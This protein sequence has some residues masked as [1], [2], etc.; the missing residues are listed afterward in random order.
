MKR[1]LSQQEIE[2]ILDDLHSNNGYKDV[3]DRV[4]EN[5]KALCR[6]KLTGIEIYPDM[7]PK[8]KEN[9]TLQYD[10]TQIHAGVCV[11]VL[12]A[13][14]LG[15]R[16]TQLVLNS[17][18]WLSE[19]LIRLDGKCQVFPIGK[20]IDNYLKNNLE[21]IEHIPENR[22]E[23]LKMDTP[24]FIPSTDENGMVGWHR[25]EAITRHLPV[26]KLIKITTQS[27]RTVSATRQKSFLRWNGTIF[28]AV[29][30]TDLQIGDIMPT[31]RKLPHVELHQTLD[32]NDLFPK[33]EYLYSSEVIK[34]VEYKKTDSRWWFNNSGKNFIVPQDSM[35]ENI[36]AGMI[37]IP[38]FMSLDSEFGFFIGIYLAEGLT[39]K[40][41]ISIS[42]KDE[43]ILER[44]VNWCNRFNI[45]T[46]RVATNVRN[47]TS[48]DLK[49]HSVL[50]TRLIFK[51]CDTGSSNKFVPKII[52]GAPLECIKGVL[53][54][55]F[56]GDGTINIKSLYISCSSA[57]KSLIEGMQFLLTYFGI[58][59]K[60]SGVQP[61][62]N[63]MLI[64]N[65][66][67][68]LFYEQLE[69][70][71]FVKQE[72]LNGVKDKKYVHE[73]GRF[74]KSYPHDRH[75]Y[76]DA[77]VK[78]EEVDSS[79]Q[80]VYD[81]TVEHTRNFQLFNGVNCLDTFHSSGITVAAVVTGVPRFKELLNTTKNPKGIATRIFF[82]QKFTSLQE[83]RS[84]VQTH[85][86]Y[87]QAKDIIQSHRI[88]KIQIR[89]W[90]PAFLKMEG[91]KSISQKNTGIILQFN[92]RLL[93]IH[94]LGLKYIANRIETEFPKTVCIYSPDCMH[95]VDVWFNNKDYTSAELWR[96]I[97]VISLGGITGLTNIF[98][99][100][101]DDE[102]LVD[103]S[104]FNMWEL[105][106]KSWIEATRTY[107]NHMWEIYEILG[108]EA[109]RE[110]LIAE[111]ITVI[112]TDSYINVRHI[113]LLVD[114][115][116]F[117]GSITSISRFGI[118]R[119]QS[120]PITKATF[121]ETL[122]NFLKAGLYGETETTLG[123]SSAIVCGKPS[124]IG[125]GLCNLLYDSG[126]IE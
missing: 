23:Y 123:V 18:D 20:F 75:V 82:K 93:F 87:V 51:L 57:S 97:P 19:I 39:T 1:K 108:I 4:L 35:F 17:V 73:F 50:L 13:Q 80:Y 120:G 6:S 83:I 49:I 59:G 84:T 109:T 53:N 103:M 28:E 91:D 95:R 26:G 40:T 33:T 116:T 37:Y 60:I 12:T 46:S 104:G 61:K 88:T 118:Q 122:D 117:S 107:S 102:W 125:T 3:S 110:Y 101:K 25:I 55:Y 90:Y 24:I 86:I 85:L 98:Y 22:T 21:F 8:L 113:Q 106:N 78:I 67:A 38:E 68:K 94:R 74:M 89:P 10:A 44:I 47:G 99:T 77:I 52:F 7:I 30:G 72:K 70:T 111:F 71:C 62:G 29:N 48:I 36:Q 119:N 42:N 66:F 45:T 16:Q 41:Y 124:I 105:L 58:F 2:F 65:G 115:M 81:L 11:G 92:P 79:N 34:A 54:G 64:R 43:K 76:F 100:K 27:G 126:A 31:T 14:S 5:T 63:T 96:D 9:I 114:I 32:M 112:S 15:E 69:L 121:E 56:S